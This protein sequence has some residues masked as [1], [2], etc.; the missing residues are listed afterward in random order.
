MRP[1]EALAAHWD[2][3][4]YMLS[5]VYA[6]VLT[7]C[8]EVPIYWQALRDRK[9]SERFVLGLS[10]SALTHPFVWF[11]FPE[12]IGALTHARPDLYYPVYVVVAETFAYGVEALYLRALGVKRGWLWSIAANST[13]LGM[14][15]VSIWLLHM[16]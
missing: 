5:W 13:S 1:L 2:V 4:S 3:S 9:R 12:V 6:F 8:C 16:P 10:A 11:L 7:Q 14:G 15:Y